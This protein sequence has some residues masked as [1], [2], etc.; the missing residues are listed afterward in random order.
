MD[1][2]TSIQHLKPGS[3]FTPAHLMGGNGDSSRN[4]TLW[5]QALGKISPEDKIGIDFTTGGLLHNLIQATQE[6]KQEIEAKRW[7]YR[8]C[9]GETVSYADKFLT[10]L[11]KYAGIVDIAIQHDPHVVAL[12]WSGF[13]FLLQVSVLIIE[14]KNVY[15]LS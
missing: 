6:K 10:L 5:Q 13:R 1:D 15:S 7:V 2:L 8:N 12:V 11:N 9:H 4:Q 14:L 3:G